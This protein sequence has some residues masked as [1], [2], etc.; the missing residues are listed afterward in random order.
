MGDKMKSKK[1][2]H[3]TTR[4]KH[5]VK[6]MNNIHHALMRGKKVKKSSTNLPYKSSNVHTEGAE[7]SFFG[8]DV[9]E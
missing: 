2:V 7:A 3:I 5:A 9:G 6:S 4:L 8:G 1:K